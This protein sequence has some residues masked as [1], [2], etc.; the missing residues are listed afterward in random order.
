MKNKIKQLIKESNLSW[1]DKMEAEILFDQALRSKETQE[2]REIIDVLEDLYKDLGNSNLFTSEYLSSKYQDVVIKSI[3]EFKLRVR[4]NDCILNTNYFQPFDDYTPITFKEFLG[5]LSKEG[6]KIEMNDGKII[7]TPQ[8]QNILEREIKH[9]EDDGC[10]Y[11]PKGFQE[12]FTS[13][14]DKEDLNIYLWT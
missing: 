8:D 2:I 7:F 14:Q 5:S 6:T 10:G 3:N 9:A 4:K 1:K 13:Y 11:A 12:V